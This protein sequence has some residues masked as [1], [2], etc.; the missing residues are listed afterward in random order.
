MATLANHIHTR[1]LRTLICKTER[2]TPSSEVCVRIT[3]HNDTHMIICPPS[4]RGWPG[5]KILAGVT[6]A[7]IKAMSQLVRG[8][9]TPPRPQERID[10]FPTCPP[11]SLPHFLFPPSLPILASLSRAGGVFLGRV[12][13]IKPL[14]VS[15]VLQGQLSFLVVSPPQGSHVTQSKTFANSRDGHSFQRPKHCISCFLCSFLPPASGSSSCTF[16]SDPQ[17]VPGLTCL[18]TA[19]ESP[20]PS[21]ILWDSLTHSP[22]PFLRAQ[23]GSPTHMYTFTLTCGARSCTPLSIKFM[24]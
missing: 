12:W 10:C 8:P 17:S 20:S 21:P 16:S 15:T 9:S 1:G 13:D 11:R 2:I 6:G 5:R 18:A 7:G 22:E 23:P 3:G 24:K 4:P 14:E 19:P